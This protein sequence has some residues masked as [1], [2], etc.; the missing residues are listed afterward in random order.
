MAVRIPAS[1]HRSGLR[2]Y[3]AEFIGTLL[4]ILIGDGVVAQAVLTDFY[5]A[6]FL[7]VNLAW[8]S[9][10]ALSCYVGAAVNPAIT[11][12]S[13]IIRPTKQQWAQLPGKVVAQFL[14][15]FV[16]AALVYLQYRSAIKAWDPEFTVPGGSILSPQGHHSAGI[17][18]T[19][20]AAH[21]GSNWEAAVTEFLGA[22]LLAFGASAVA[23]PKN[24][25]L[26]APQ[27]MMFALMVAIGA[28]MGWQTGYAVNPARDFGPRL[29][30]AIVYGREVFSAKGFY[31]VVPL[32]V[33]IFGA[34][35]GAGIY[36]AFMFEGEGSA[37][38]DALDAAEGHDGRISL[39]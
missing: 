25:G 22:S 2:P 30:S 38:A 10:V 6:N 24:E 3:L 36:D 14:G 5:Y 4:L 31:F 7:S 33:P 12:A 39:D 35:A 21:F 37:V 13:A 18:A 34:I 8:A 23:D 26:K 17:F 29:F 19:Y 16:G 15:A 11:L 28:S 1:L 32:F 20:P 9:A 27:F